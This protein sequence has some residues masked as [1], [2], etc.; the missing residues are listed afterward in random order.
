MSIKTISRIKRKFDR[1]GVYLNYVTFVMSLATMLKV[2]SITAWW[3]YA[4]GI[5]AIVL[6]RCIAGYIDDRV[7]IL[8]N[9]QDQLTRKNLE[10][11][12]LIEKIDEILKR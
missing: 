3:I 5:I 6:L 2:F 9:E 10:W 1:G 12:K 8:S 4:I 11:N 7:G